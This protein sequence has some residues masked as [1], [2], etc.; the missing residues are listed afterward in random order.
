MYVSGYST[1]RGTERREAGQGKRNDRD[2]LEL[3]PHIRAYLHLAL[4]AAHPA[5]QAVV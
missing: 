2:V 4:A 1:V 5:L 3:L